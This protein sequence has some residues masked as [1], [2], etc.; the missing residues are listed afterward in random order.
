MNAQ[1][2]LTPEEQVAQEAQLRTERMGFFLKEKGL[3][4]LT[5]S[6]SKA[7]ANLELAQERYNDNPSEANAEALMK[8]D[9]DAKKAE[10]I[11]VGVSTRVSHEAIRKGELNPDLTFKENYEG[12]FQKQRSERIKNET[13]E[14]EYEQA[15]EDYKKYPSSETANAMIKKAPAVAKSMNQ[16]WGTVADTQSALNI[17]KERLVKERAQEFAEKERV[18]NGLEEE[19]RPR[20]SSL[21]GHKSKPDSLKTEMEKEIEAKAKELLDNH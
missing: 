5:S 11:A 13:Q 2:Q 12:S 6:L 18:Y 20:Y 19:D 17:L 15:K 16:E 14:K 4:H 3:A 10:I 8:A 7:V 21:V 1:Q 9:E